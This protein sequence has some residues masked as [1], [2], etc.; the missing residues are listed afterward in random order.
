MM[1]AR[2]ED[3]YSDNSENENSSDSNDNLGDSNIEHE[4]LEYF[5]ASVSD[6]TFDWSQVTPISSRELN[7]KPEVVELDEESSDSEVEILET[8]HSVSGMGSKL[9]RHRKACSADRTIERHGN[10]SENPLDIEDYSNSDVESEVR[11][12]GAPREELG[13]NVENNGLYTEMANTSVSD[14][15]ESDDT[16]TS[17]NDTVEAEFALVDPIDE[18]SPQSH[19]SHILQGDHESLNKRLVTLPSVEANTSSHTAPPES[20]SS[21]KILNAENDSESFSASVV[22]T[23]ADKQITNRTSNIASRFEDRLS[24]AS[25]IEKNEATSQFSISLE[26]EHRGAAPRKT[27]SKTKPVNNAAV[28]NMHLVETGRNT[29]AIENLISHHAQTFPVVTDFINKK[30]KVE[31]SEGDSEKMSLQKGSSQLSEASACNTSEDRKNLKLDTADPVHGTNSSSDT[32]DR[33]ISDLE[34]NSKRRKLTNARAAPESK[35]KHFATGAL[36]GVLV[37][38]LG[39]FAALAASAPDMV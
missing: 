16:E 2:S 6:N 36:A 22:V 20:G 24:I 23:E 37:G 12:K 7:V 18:S 31:I 14:R 15:E 35:L 26:K 19:P 27:L 38:S 25:L 10:S 34:R 17:P 8:T 28:S 3:E 4:S 13:T 1:E 39:M 5:N 33:E 32:L 30:R 29:V 21:A 11:H 9:Y